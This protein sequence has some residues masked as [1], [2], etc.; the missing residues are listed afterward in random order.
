MQG[1]LISIYHPK[2]AP[3]VFY[4]KNTQ[5]LILPLPGTAL[6]DVAL[7]LISN[8]LLHAI[9]CL[10]HQDIDI[11]S[12]ISTLYDST[13]V[14]QWAPHLIRL[15]SKQYDTLFTRTFSI[16][17]TYA[18]NTCSSPQEAYR[19]RSYALLCL[20]RTRSNIVLAQTFWDQSVK[21]AA[22]YIAAA[23]PEEDSHAA[24]EVLDTFQELTRCVENRDDKAE[25]MQ[26]SGFTAF[27]EHWVT[28][29]N[30]VSRPY[31]LHFAHLVIC[32]FAGR[33]F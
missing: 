17:T 4:S 25:F 1:P 26:G 15:P 32:S 16:L 6:P 10:C 33:K 9:T 27:C 29:A 24:Q 23:P 18:T 19:L 13:F 22:S 28:C 2:C 14:I 20:S 31:V 30:L 5:L 7:S 12:L 8:Y 21:F 3:S 11:P